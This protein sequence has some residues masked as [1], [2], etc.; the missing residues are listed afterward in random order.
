MAIDVEA[1]LRD[2]VEAGMPAVIAWFDM[3]R[4][5]AP[6]AWEF[7][8]GAST[9]PHM[10][11]LI[12]DRDLWRFAY[13]ETSKEFHA[14]LSS[15]TQDFTLWSGLED[16][17]HVVI[18]GMAILRAHNVNVQKLVD[19]AYFDSIDIHIIPVVNAP[20]FYASDVGHALLQKF[21][22]APFAAC[23]YKDRNKKLGYSLRSQ[24][25]RVDVSEVAKRFGGGGHRNEA[26]FALLWE[27]PI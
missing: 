23:W 19:E 6:M 4:S 3:N 18:E 2:A 21:P 13:G 12:E 20:Y 14:A 22:S 27:T 9:M 16:H 10:L 1:Y 11:T 7:A 17:V 25:H 26:G 8:H 15:Y 5:G 24:D